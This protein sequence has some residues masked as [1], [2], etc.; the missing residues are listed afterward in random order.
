MRADATVYSLNQTSKVKTHTMTSS[1][2][3][4]H[5]GA[6]GSQAVHGV[7]MTSGSVPAIHNVMLSKMSSTIAAETKRETREELSE[8]SSVKYTSSYTLSLTLNAWKR[9]GSC[10]W[11]LVGSSVE[12]FNSA[13]MACLWKSLLSTSK[14]ASKRCNAERIVA[15]GSSP[16][17]GYKAMLWKALTT[18]PCGTKK[19]LAMQ[20]RPLSF[21]KDSFHVVMT[22]AA[23]RIRSSPSAVSS[24]NLLSASEDCMPDTTT[25]VAEAV[26]SLPWPA[27]SRT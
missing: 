4:I 18:I 7:T 9:M 14:A 5:A 8:T 24:R 15:C 17:H 26:Q 21:I 13:T 6:R 3:F 2:S 27:I 11:T 1:T 12:R 20:T 16:G 23:K 25:G 19:S 10:Q 22:D